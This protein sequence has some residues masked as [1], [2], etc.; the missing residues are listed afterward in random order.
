MTSR[1]QWLGKSE[2]SGRQGDM[3][4]PINVTMSIG[5]HEDSNQAPCNDPLRT[6]VTHKHMI[7]PISGHYLIYHNPEA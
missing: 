4:L 7:F 5:E 2:V 6:S 3:L 1:E